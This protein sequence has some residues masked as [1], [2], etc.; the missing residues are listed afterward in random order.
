MHCQR[1]SI[2]A[3]CLRELLSNVHRESS[4]PR[5]NRI[6]P[7]HSNDIMVL[8]TLAHPPRSPNLRLS[9]KPQASNPCFPSPLKARSCQPDCLKLGSIASSAERYFRH[10]SSRRRARN[11]P[12]HSISFPPS[13]SRD[14]PPWAQRGCFGLTAD[15]HPK[16]IPQANK[17]KPPREIDPNSGEIER[18][19]VCDGRCGFRRV[20][21]SNV[22]CR[23]GVRSTWHSTAGDELLFGCGRFHLI[24]ERYRYLERVT[25]WSACPAVLGTH[26]R[27]QDFCSLWVPRAGRP[28]QTSKGAL[29]LQQR[30]EVPRGRCVR[31]PE[32]PHP[33]AQRSPLP[34]TALPTTPYPKDRLWTEG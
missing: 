6:Y 12:Q 22:K 33:L 25:L 21:V 29:E 27:P 8:S 14:S 20:I 2:G 15:S 5:L 24:C 18:R 11:L 10:P 34:L 17:R 1:P 9:L 32:V 7:Q 31:G 16:I 26:P 28:Q 19:V 23:V 13:L 3:S 30:R 4:G